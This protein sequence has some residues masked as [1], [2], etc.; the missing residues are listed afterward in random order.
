MQYRL[1][2][3]HVQ[4]DPADAH[5]PHQVSGPPEVTERPQATALL[6]YLVI[7]L[8]GS[9]N[10]VEVTGI[11]FDDIDGVDSAGVDQGIENGLRDQLCG[12]GLFEHF[13][14]PN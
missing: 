1:V 4:P 3:T 6:F 8:R 13:G 7:K 12:E 5:I 11:I 14:N 10:D 2:L 9:G